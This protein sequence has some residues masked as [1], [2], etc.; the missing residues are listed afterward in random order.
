MCFFGMQDFCYYANAIFVTCLLFFPNN[1]KLFLVC[2][3]FA[4]VSAMLL[5]TFNLFLLCLLSLAMSQLFK[6]HVRFSFE[7]HSTINNCAGTIGMG[8][9]CVAV[10]PCLQLH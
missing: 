3:S 2:F 8:T 5:K 9:D 10:Q 7:L 1:D 4:E 6:T